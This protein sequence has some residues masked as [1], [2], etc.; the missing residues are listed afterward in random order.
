VVTFLLWLLTLP[1]RLSGIVVDGVFALLRAIVAMPVK[2]SG[3]RR[4]T[5]AAG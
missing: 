4:G 2:V 3:W 1:L 5:R